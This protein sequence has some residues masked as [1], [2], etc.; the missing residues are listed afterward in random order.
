M[1]ANTIVIPLSVGDAL[2]LS[3]GVI[4]GMMARSFF[5]TGL[6]CLAEALFGHRLPLM[7]GQSG[8][9]WSSILSL[10]SVFLATGQNSASI[11]GGMELG[12]IASG[13]LVA[14]FGVFGLDRILNRLFTP[15]V[16]AVLLILLSAQL[17][18]IFFDGMM[19]VTQGNGE[20]QP[21]VALISILLVL[22]VGSITVFSRGLLG[23]FAILIGMSIGW[24]AYVLVFGE[25]LAQ[26]P[27]AKDMFQPFVWGK[28]SFST[29]IMLSMLVVGVVNTTNTVATL[30]AAQPVFDEEILSDRYRRSLGVTGAFTVLAGVFGIVPYAPYTSSIGFLRTTRI[31]TRLPFMLGAVFLILLGIVPPFVGFFSSMPISVGDAVLFVA[32]L[33]LFGSALQSIDTYHF[34]FR[35]IFRVAFPVLTGLAI[36]STP[37]A[38]F[39]TLPGAVQPLCSNGM[40]VGII[41]S[42]ILESCINWSKLENA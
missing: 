17:I 27:S 35:T 24:L 3:S 31:L 16:M 21:R 13:V 36:L 42:V 15:V 37:S 5:I 33:Q 19:G 14:L 28:P 9:W 12:I 41:L 39:K 30:R 25:H 11:G 38:A 22:L 20:I 7:E 32:Y 18:H 10:A 34:N 6:A 40:L 8:N 26:M 23:N 1:F 2:H 4:S 29:G